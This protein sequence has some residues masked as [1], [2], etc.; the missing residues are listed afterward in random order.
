MTMK[1]IPR[2]KIAHLPTPVETL[3]RLSNALGGQKILVKRDD[4]TGLA[5]G[6][7]KIRKLE[8]LLAEAQANGAR[9]VITMGAVQ[10]NH[11]RQTAAAAARFNFD[12]IL[13]LS[14]EKPAVVS[15]NLLLD[16]LFGAEFVFT[17]LEKRGEVLQQTFEQAW[18]QGRRPYLIPYGGS[19][20]TGATAYAFAMQELLEQNCRPDWIVFASS[21][22]G[23]QA[24][25]VVG[26]SLFDFRGKILGISV[27]ET[28][29]I[30]QTRVADL[31]NAT[32]D[33]LGEKVKFQPQDILV[34]ADY[35]GDGYGIM[36]KP[37]IEAIQLFAREEGLLLDPVYTGRAGAGLI[38]LIRKGFFKPDE[39]VLFWHT[40][41][42]PALFSEKYQ[43]LASR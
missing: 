22:A 4:M 38:D 12:C 10:S 36:G 23:T 11:C 6:G 24:G 37:E 33:M 13:V 2:L 18:E 16:Q 21:S 32:A 20:T 5:M 14:G 41:G 30:L 15:G 42:I 1:N 29:E 35:L 3:P 39:S 19:N 40:G 28:K 25:L 9:T 8:F 7:N 26:A 43:Q 31:A 34:S 17:S 27:D